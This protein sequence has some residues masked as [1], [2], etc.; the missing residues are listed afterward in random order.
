MKGKLTLEI[1]IDYA[2]MLQKENLGAINL[3]T[4][5]R[6]VEGMVKVHMDRLTALITEP[7]KNMPLMRYRVDGKLITD[8]PEET[9]DPSEAEEITGVDDEI[10]ER[11]S[12]AE[13]SPEVSEESDME[14][15]EYLFKRLDEAVEHVSLN[16]GIIKRIKVSPSTMD[17]LE[18]RFVEEKEGSNQTDMC[19]YQG[20]D[21]E[22]EGMEEN[23]MIVY[24]EYS[25]GKFNHYTG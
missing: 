1:D 5:E 21:L 20:F 8:R 9:L 12:D 2:T 7:V 15:E 18:K 6:D 4:G 24:K 23:F 11:E 16:L 22:V 19:K 10:E 25:G 14:E 3:F 17:K 13:G